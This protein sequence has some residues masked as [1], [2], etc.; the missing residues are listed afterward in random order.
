MT[1]ESMS[2]INRSNSETAT[3]K[4]DKKLSK[5]IRAYSRK[6]KSEL[7]KDLKKQQKKFHIENQLQL[8]EPNSSDTQQMENAQSASINADMKN[9]LMDEQISHPKGCCSFLSIFQRS[10]KSDANFKKAQQASRSKKGRLINKTVKVT[11]K[12]HANKENQVDSDEWIK[13]V[14]KN[15]RFLEDSIW[16]KNLEAYLKVNHDTFQSTKFRSQIYFLNFTKQQMGSQLVTSPARARVE[17]QNSSFAP[18]YKFTHK[19]SQ[20]PISTNLQEEKKSTQI[21]NNNTQKY[22]APKSKQLSGKSQ[23]MYTKPNSK[24][25]ESEMTQNIDQRYQQDK[26]TIVK[27]TYEEK[28][29]IIKSF[30]RNDETNQEESIKIEH[31]A[32]ETK[33]D[34]DLSD[35]YANMQESNED[36]LQTQFNFQRYLYGMPNQRKQNESLESMDNHS[37]LL[38]EV[39]KHQLENNSN[40]LNVLCQVFSAFFIKHYKNI[41]ITDDEQTQY[42][43]ITEQDGLNFELVPI[44]EQQRPF[45]ESSLLTYLSQDVDT[46]LED[47]FLSRQFDQAR[48]SKFKKQR[49]TFNRQGSLPKKRKQTLK[50]NEKIKELYKTANQVLQDMKFFSCIIYGSCV[51]FYSTVAKSQ[52]LEGMREDLI[53][54]IMGVV[55]KQRLSNFLKQI[56][57]IVTKD[58]DKELQQQIQKFRYLKLNQLGLDSKFCLDESSQI[59]EKFNEQVAQELSNNGDVGGSSGNLKAKKDSS[60]KI[61]KPQ[62]QS[63]QIQSQQEMSSSQN[64]LFLSSRPFQT[65]PHFHEEEKTERFYSLKIDHTQ[66]NEMFFSMLS[67]SDE[68]EIGSDQENQEDQINID[69]SPS[70]SQIDLIQILHKKI[71]KRLGQ[72][73]YYRAIREFQS[74]KECYAPLDKMRCLLRLSKVIVKSINSFWK[75]INI[76]RDKLTIDGD[77]L[78]DIYIYIIINSDIESLFAQIKFMTTFTTPHVLNITKLGYC[79]D[80]LTVALRHILN[81]DSENMTHLRPNQRGHNN[82]LNN[83]Y[84]NNHNNRQS[85]QEMQWMEDRKSLTRNL[86]KS[87]ASSKR[88]ESL[89]IQDDPTDSYFRFDSLKEQAF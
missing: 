1:N 50:P 18:M 84:Q 40:P 5:E 75:D 3:P 68:D 36:R 10:K 27:Y 88:T 59:M 30:K 9:T 77:S 24:T 31:F 61:K 76:D 21:S 51:R 64:E 11:Y 48:S 33:S 63:Q 43:L 49:A 74:L 23:T 56:C 41:V 6:K 79:L 71:E 47:E 22:P 16:A 62:Q 17:S 28:S 58:D 39:I 81:F 44:S 54:S 65:E 7:V 86:K 87:L 72:Q 69:V 80:T 85:Q 66:D 42:Y 32:E 19:P 52:D 78:I 14:E 26:E 89:L 4:I 55:M 8:I 2:L 57:Q 67:Q 37:K 15:L 29:Q 83:Q 20:R 82:N 12:I 38:F 53:E 13:Y 35:I 73:P 34:D 70:K 46:V 45:I 60:S 25:M